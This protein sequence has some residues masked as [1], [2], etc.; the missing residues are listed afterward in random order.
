[1][2]SQIAIWLTVSLAVWRWVVVCRPHAA[3]TLCNA[4]RAR[5]LLLAVYLAC[6][7]VSIPTF[8]LYTVEEVTVADGDSSHVYLVNMSSN[9][10][11]KEVSVVREVVNEAIY[12]HPLRGL[13]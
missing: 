5:R 11:L 2:L 10:L 7:L 8:F 9:K 12:Q 6:P 13:S 1:M 3:V 4:S